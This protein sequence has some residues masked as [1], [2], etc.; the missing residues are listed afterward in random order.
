MRSV[1]QASAVRS[2]SADGNSAS[3]GIPSMNS[4]GQ[5]SVY[6]WGTWGSGSAQVQVSPDGSTW[7]NAG[8]AITANGVVKLTDVACIAVRV[9]LS[10]STNPALS[11]QAIF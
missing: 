11:I 6:V 4:A 1:P 10:G 8:S 5:I 7:F 3:I 9:A 2:L